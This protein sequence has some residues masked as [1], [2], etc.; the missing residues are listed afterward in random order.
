MWTFFRLT[1]NLHLPARFLG[2]NSRLALPNFFTIAGNS[3]DSQEVKSEKCFKA[4]S[5]ETFFKGRDHEWSG[6]VVFA[7]SKVIFFF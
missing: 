2:I 5:E 1:V 6:F 4:N 3:F 7:V